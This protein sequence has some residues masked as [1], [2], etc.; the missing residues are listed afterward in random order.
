[1][2]G[3]SNGWVQTFDLMEDGRPARVTTVTAV[4]EDCTFDWT[5][6]SRNEPTATRAA[7]DS[8]W[9]TFELDP[10]FFEDAKRRK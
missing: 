6:V 3:G 10:D 9:A 2:V 4:I 5:L 8:W 1:V 7:F